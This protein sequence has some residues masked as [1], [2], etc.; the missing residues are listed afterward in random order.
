MHTVIERNIELHCGDILHYQ[1]HVI[2]SGDEH[3]TS[4]CEFPV[5]K[6][7][8]RHNDPVRRILCVTETCLLERDPNSYG[9]VTLRPLSDVFALVRDQD[10]P[11]KLIVEYIRGGNRIYTSSDR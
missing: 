3:I 2:C 8:H 11:Q 9:I 5:H 4:L 6:V 7:S 1:F 10:N